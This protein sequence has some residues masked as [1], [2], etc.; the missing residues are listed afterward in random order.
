MATDEAN[1]WRQRALQAEEALRKHG[2]IVSNG[3]PSTSMGSHSGVGGKRR[4]LEEDKPKGVS[5]AKQKFEDE[6]LPDDDYYILQQRLVPPAAWVRSMLRRRQSLSICSTVAPEKQPALTDVWRL[7]EEY[8]EDLFESMDT[9]VYRNAAYAR[10]FA[11]VASS[12]TRWVEIGCGAAAT[13]TKIALM[14]GPANLHV[15]AFEVNAESAAAAAKTI[16]ETHGRRVNILVGRSTDHALMP[17]PTKR[18]DVLLHEV[19]GVFASSEG[20]VPMLNHGAEHYLASPRAS[21]TSPAVA[22]LHARPRPVAPR[23]TMWDLCHRYRVTEL[24]KE[25][26]RRKVR[27]VQEVPQRI[28]AQAHEAGL[29][30]R[31]IP[32]RSG[33]FFTLCD[34]DGQ[35]LDACEDVYIDSYAKPKSIL[36]PQAPIGEISLTGSSAVLDM[37]DF[38]G[39]QQ[40]KEATGAAEDVQTREHVFTVIHDGV[41]NSIGIFIWVD[42]GIGAPAD[43]PESPTDEEELDA[44]SGNSQPGF[45]HQFPFGSNLSPPD[46]R[47]NDFTSL[48]TAQTIR[49]QTYAT[50]WMNPLLLL[51]TPTPVSKGDRVRVRSCSSAGTITPSYHFELFHLPS[52]GGK[53]KDGKGEANAVPLGKL[54]VSF[55]DIYPYYE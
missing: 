5:A 24:G 22:S 3:E 42:L 14:H 34:L 43:L 10:A 16:R 25:R 50:N 17:P 27:K 19:F 35:D 7:C 9:D 47:L 1:Y 15:T 41:L 31:C 18:F 53:R 29:G 11:A 55:R 4:T 52:Q 48:C 46:A 20:C 13:L 45:E 12:Q 28:K 37:Q 49:D 32:S 36:V 21:A 44:G 40:D 6:S 33:T 51:P 8:D 23:Q 54:D 30:S 39:S 2:V 38:G 26:K